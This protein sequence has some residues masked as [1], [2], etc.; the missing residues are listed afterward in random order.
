MSRP[1]VVFLQP[2]HRPA[3]EPRAAWDEFRAVFAEAGWEV[4]ILPP[5]GL[6]WNPFARMHNAFSGLDPLRALRVLLTRRHAAV[7][8]GH[9]ESPCLVLVWLRGLF[10][11]R[12][13]VVLWEV[14]WSIGWRYRDWLQRQTIP[15]VARSVVFG[16]SQLALLARLFGPAARG[17]FQ[18]MGIDVA[19]FAPMAG[20]RADV[21]AVGR[22]AGRDWALLLAATRGME[23]PV[24][25]KA[26]RSPVRFDP[27]EHPNVRL[28]EHYLPQDAFRQ[29]YADAAAVVITTLETDNACGVTSLL[30]GLAMGRPV[31]V[32]DNPALRDYIPPPDACIV[33][34]IGDEA[35][36]R[37]AVARVL[38]DPQAAEAMGQRG[39]A[40]VQARFGPRATHAR[41]L[42]LL[43]EVAEEAGTVDADR[44]A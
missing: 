41:M 28:I 35:G 4:E 16:T 2:Q 5:M 33:V 24:V 18:P 44:T 22:D 13:P 12:P 19:Y 40:W 38:A 31:I 29:L 10:R 32:S 25:I 36:L 8:V 42:A 39:R 7:I 30:E 11:F 26:G 9:S 17:V 15:R 34:G 43:R 3:D 6:P 14:S 20:R 21:L 37:A 27:R 23:V 1:L